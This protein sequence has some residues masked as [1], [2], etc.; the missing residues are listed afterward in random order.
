MAAKKGT[1][2]LSSEKWSKKWP[3]FIEKSDG[4]YR[5]PRI[6]TDPSGVTKAAN[7]YFVEKN[8]FVCGKPTLKD[9]SN[10]MGRVCCSKECQYSL[11]KKPDGTKKRKRGNSDSHIMVKSVGHPYANKDGYIAEH[12]LLI[13]KKIGRLLLPE[14]HVHHINLVKDDNRLENLILCKDASQH[15]KAHGTLNKCVS[16]LVEK[17]ILRFNRKS[18]SYEVIC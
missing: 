6:W 16:E 12:R 11:S 4:R 8:C 7:S 1:N 14:E 15:F 18:F 17:G 3:G 10:K 2:L 13:E 9:V 5:K